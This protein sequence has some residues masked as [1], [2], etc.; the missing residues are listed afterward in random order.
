MHSTLVGKQRTTLRKRLSTHFASKVLF[1][2][3]RTLYVI[4]ERLLCLALFSTIWIF[5]HEVSNPVM[6]PFHMVVS[7]MFILTRI[8]TMRALEVARIGVRV[9]LSD[10]RL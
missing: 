8:G 10:M 3:V 2:R 5:A 6:H 1:F 7:I 9:H 4:L